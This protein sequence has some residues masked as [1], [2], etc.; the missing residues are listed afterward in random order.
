MRCALDLL[1]VGVLDIGDPLA[2]L[3]ERLPV[4]EPAG[5]R[6]ASTGNPTASNGANSASAVEPGNSG[7]SA[8]APSASIA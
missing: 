1:V 2:D 3:R 4:A 6:A 5:V 7:A 8:S